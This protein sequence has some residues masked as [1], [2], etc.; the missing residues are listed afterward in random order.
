MGT[1]LINM[2]NTA[3]DALVMSAKEKNKVRKGLEMLGAILARVAGEGLT[4][5]VIFELS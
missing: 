1:L 5:K 2:K 4:A 3:Y